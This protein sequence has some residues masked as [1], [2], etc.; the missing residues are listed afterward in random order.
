MVRALIV[1][2][3]W[4]GI[5]FCLFFAMWFATGIVMHFVPFPALTEAERIGGLTPINVQAI[6][7]GPAEAVRASALEATERVRL[8]QRSD[9]P[10]YLLSGP[11]GLRALSAADLS[12][13]AVTSEQL[14]LAIAM[15]HARRRELDASRATV[16]ALA[17]Y[18]QWTVPNGL[19]PH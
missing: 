18:D 3:R 5:A 2:H 16:A 11:A 10:V 9:A 4:L 19:D 15:D 13:G 6:R 17:H 1:L 7:H 12:S 8:L 14:A